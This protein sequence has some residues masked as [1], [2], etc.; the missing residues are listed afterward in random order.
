MPVRNTN[1]ESPVAKRTRPRRSVVLEDESQ[2]SAV[3]SLV[4][5]L[6]LV[7]GNLTLSAML[8]TLTF[9]ITF[10]ELASVSRHVDA[11]GEVGAL[12]AWKAFELGLAWMFDFDGENWIYE[13]I[14]DGETK[15]TVLT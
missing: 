3:N 15:M 13:T 14:C 8:F 11:W 1:T 7:V 2:P 9:E 6:S 4:A 12:I 5:F 10:N